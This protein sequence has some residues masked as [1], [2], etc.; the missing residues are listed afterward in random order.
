MIKIIYNQ[1]SYDYESAGKQE[2]DINTEIKLND[3]IS[4]IEAIEAF[5]KLLNIA[6]YRVSI[7]TLE[8][9][10]QDLKDEGYEETERIR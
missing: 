8:R 7:D 5:L 2:Y 9:V 1:E 10:I 6:T 3:D 4:S